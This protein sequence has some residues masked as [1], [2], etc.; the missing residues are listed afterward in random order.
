MNVTGYVRSLPLFNPQVKEVYR[1]WERADQEMLEIRSLA[2]RTGASA[3]DLAA[4]DRYRDAHRSG[5]RTSKVAD[6]MLTVGKPLMEGGL[7]AF[8]GAL[9]L[10][11]QVTSSLMG[12]LGL[13]MGTVVA[14]WAGIGLFFGGLHIARKYPDAAIQ[15]LDWQDRAVAGDLLTRKQD[16]LDQLQVTR[17]VEALKPQTTGP[18]IATRGNR[19]VIGGVVIKVR[20]D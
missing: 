14:S 1:S 19:M 20:P 11:G 12:H 18:A 4:L 3:G 6:A 5:V 7:I 13:I 10:G 16:M 15:K 8:G 2:E 9:L 17:M